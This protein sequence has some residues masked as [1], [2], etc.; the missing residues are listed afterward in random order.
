MVDI[1]YP[2]SLVVR[3]DGPANCRQPYT[4]SATSAFED[5]AKVQPWASADGHVESSKF[6]KPGRIEVNLDLT[7]ADP[8]AVPAKA[9]AIIIIRKPGKPD[10]FA[11]TD[12][13]KHEPELKK[14]V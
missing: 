4:F 11:P 10:P 6:T 8:E 13:P 3:I 7:A 2:Q 9:T 5:E 12:V 14:S 1:E